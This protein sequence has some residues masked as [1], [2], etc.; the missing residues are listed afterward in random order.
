MRVSR[1]ICKSL[2]VA[3]LLI[4]SSAQAVE[5]VNNAHGDGL[6][7]FGIYGRVA[8]SITTGSSKFEYH[9][10][11]PDGNMGH[12]LYYLAT[13][14]D[15]KK[16]GLQ[17]D[18]VDMDGIERNLL[19][20]VAG[21]RISDTATVGA[22]ANIFASP[23][24]DEAGGSLNFLTHFETHFRKNL[25]RNNRDLVVLSLSMA[26]YGNVNA[27]RVSKTGVGYEPF[28]KNAKSVRVTYFKDHPDLSFS[29]YYALPTSAHVNQAVN[30][31][32]TESYGVSMGYKHNFAPRHNVD[33]S[34]GATRALRN[35][36]I[37]FYEDRYP[38][39]PHTE[40]GF[41]AGVEYNY[42]N[43]KVGA[44][45]GYKHGQ[46]DGAEIFKSIDTLSYA[47]KVGYNFTPRLNA[48][49]SFDGQ[50]SKSKGASPDAL[51]VNK[52]FTNAGFNKSAKQQLEETVLFDK[53][54][55]RQLTV[56]AEYKITPDLTAETQI[57]YNNIDNYVPEG[58][59]TSVKLAE[60][61][62]GLAYEF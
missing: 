22:S 2:P 42:V 18:P 17:R 8:P 4:G 45:L 47:L 46:V 6:N 44:D 50:D 62:A 39:L 48:Y 27:F 51:S 34:L 54:N 20:I 33:I 25:G 9:Y 11:N 32:I 58:K 55:R 29:G 53:I 61:S 38:G 15:N 7:R 30:K 41:G 13:N 35:P 14:Q 59:F 24:K 12:L 3:L 60:Y 37:K 43:W 26:P 1:F 56:G 52:L 36:K 57:K 16:F 5:L 19:T 49:V 10:G 28:A 31:D 40:D 21:R 23:K